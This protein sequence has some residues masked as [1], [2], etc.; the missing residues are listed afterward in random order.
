MKKSEAEILLE[1]PEKMTSEGEFGDDSVNQFHVSRRDS[2]LLP[3]DN[4]FD[5]IKQKITKILMGFEEGTD[6]IQ[7]KRTPSVIDSDEIRRILQNLKEPKFGIKLPA[8]IM[9][10]FVQKYYEAQVLIMGVNRRK[11]FAFKYE[12]DKNGVPLQYKLVDSINLDM[13]ESCQY[14]ARSKM[15]NGVVFCSHEEIFSVTYQIETK[16]LKKNLL[17]KLDDIREALDNTIQT[18]DNDSEVYSHVGDISLRFGEAK[19]FYS[20]EEEEK[21]L[22]FS[23]LSDFIISKEGTAEKGRSSMVLLFNYSKEE[24][25]GGRILKFINV[26]DYI[27]NMTMTS[28]RLNT[29]KIYYIR[30]KCIMEN[31]LKS[32]GNNHGRKNSNFRKDEFNY[33]KMV[34]RDNTVIQQFEFDNQGKHIMALM[35]GK[36]KKIY[37]YNKKKIPIYFE[38]ENPVADFAVS[39]DYLFTGDASS[40]LKI[41][42]P[43]TN[44]IIND[45]NLNIDEEVDEK[46]IE[47]EGI[48][49]D[50]TILKIGLFGKSDEPT[51]VDIIIND[52]YSELIVI[53]TDKLIFWQIPQKQAV[54]KLKID[55]S[56]RSS[57]C[58]LNDGMTFL[59]N[60][61]NQ[62]IQRVRNDSLKITFSRDLPLNT[63]AVRLITNGDVFI[64]RKNYD[65]KRLNKNKL[66]GFNCETVVLRIFGPKLLEVEEVFRTPKLVKSMDVVYKSYLDDEYGVTHL[67]EFGV[68][69]NLQDENL[70]IVNKMEGGN[71]QPK[72]LASHDINAENFLQPVKN[73]GFEFN[74]DIESNNEETKTDN[75]FETEQFNNPNKGHNLNE[76]GNSED[77]YGTFAKLGNNNFSQLK[78]FQYI[79]EINYFVGY[80]IQRKSEDI[81][82]IHFIAFNPFKSSNPRIV[83]PNIFIQNHQEHGEDCSYRIWI[84]RME[85]SVYVIG[86]NCQAGTFM[87]QFDKLTGKMVKTQEIRQKSNLNVSAQLV[88]GEYVYIPYLNNMQIYDY[89]QGKKLYTIEIESRV[90]ETFKSEDGEFVGIIDSQNFYLVDVEKMIIIQKHSLTNRE[91]QTKM[92]ILDMRFFP[93]FKEYLLPQFNQDVMVLKILDQSQITGLRYM[94]V[95]HLAKCFSTKDNKKSIIEFANFYSKTIGEMDCFDYIFGPLN[96]FIFAIFYSEENILQL[97]LEKFNFPKQVKNFTTPVEYCFLKKEN[98]CLRILCNILLA[99]KKDVYFTMMEFQLLL[100]SDFEFCDTLLIKIPLKIPYDKMNFSETMENDLDF[101]LNSSVKQFMIENEQKQFE[102]ENTEVDT[103]VSRDRI[104]IKFVPFTYD[105]SIGSQDSLQFLKRYASS[106]SDEFIKSD[107]KTVINKRWSK[108]KTLY[109]FN[110]MIFWIYMFFCTWSIVFNLKIG[111]D[112]LIEGEIYSEVRYCALAF[113][114]IVAFLEVLQMIAYCR[115]DASLYFGDFWNY[116]DIM[117]LIFAFLFF[118]NLYQFFNQP[119]SLFI[120][121]M[122]IMLIFYRGFSYFRFFSSFMTMVGVI[123]TIVSSSLSFFGVLFYS[124]VV[125]LFMMIKVEPS[126]SLTSKIRDAYIFSLFG[127]IEQDHFEAKYIFFPIMVGTMI[128]T[129]I[130]LNVLIAFMSNVYNKMEAKQII[131]SYQE[132]SSMLLDMEVYISLFQSINISR[133]TRKMRP[134]QKKEFINNKKKIAFFLT[135]VEGVVS[136]KGSDNSLVQ[137]RSLE[138]QILDLE[139]SLRKIHSRNEEDF[140]SIKKKINGVR[141]FIGFEQNEISHFDSKMQGILMNLFDDFSKGITDNVMSKIEKKFQLDDFPGTRK[142]KNNERRRVSLINFNH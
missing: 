111:P 27:S 141:K 128:V 134:E 39:G 1:D 125:I 62:A 9:V 37:K 135:K 44:S 131:I 82:H 41:W 70:I 30:G 104:D 122:L 59:M 34:Y 129:I 88:G 36:V 142:K 25:K 61:A 97:L 67:P 136:S 50:K 14:M 63:Y 56:Y 35:D 74:L 4:S 138:A 68:L 103:E 42:N 54:I 23:V 2:L 106:K 7:I 6:K 77:G 5:E 98:D 12:I 91:N 66:K 108:L 96:P 116:I 53:M 84:E 65:E 117:A 139:K 15:E 105:F 26:P 75:Y 83:I 80:L 19:L 48:E 11:V 79:R 78:G 113:N 100:E 121:L 8:G 16:E 115:F 137:M 140:L 99:N 51:I 102:A 69:L 57:V 40:T 29:N 28:Y 130:L 38:Q 120:A 18:H 118:T 72:D 47:L 64:A 33:E 109:I 13:L 85:T 86:L 3:K 127:G 92:M 43:I 114:I 94:P 24:S 124:Y 107:W 93:H 133:K 126:D 46:F 112:G 73:A 60:S 52:D 49:S 119:G 31:Y 95:D 55:I 110:A 32:F 71:Y 89:V 17:L 76:S 21:F 20:E 22:L 123:N 101:R 58:F 87:V 90:L 45:L 132:K 10:D 81:E